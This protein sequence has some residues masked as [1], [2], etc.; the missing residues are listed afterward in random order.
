[1][2]QY[3]SLRE[4]PEWVSLETARGWEP[5]ERTG[6][7]YELR[8]TSAAIREDGTV[9]L[10]AW[11][12]IFRLR[13]A[14]RQEILEPVKILGDHWER[15]YGDLEWRGILPE[16]VL[17]WYVLVTD[18]N[19]VFGWGVKTQP[20]A[21]CSFRFE[22]DR[23]IL[24]LDVRCGGDGV[25]LNGSELPAAALVEFHSTE[26]PFAAAQAFCR[27]LCEAPRM[28]DGPI[29]GGNDWYSA[30]GNNSSSLILENSRMVAEWAGDNEVRPFMVIDD[31]WQIC[32]CPVRG[33]NGGP[34]MMSNRKFP[35]GMEAI[36]SR[37]KELGVRPGIWFRPLQTMEEAPA[38]WYLKTKETGTFLDPS[39]DGVLEWV[40]KDVKRL[41]DWGFELIKHDYS[42]YDIFGRWGFQMGEELTEPGWH[43]SR[44]DLTTAQVLKRF[45]QTLRNAAG[46]KA[47]LI[48]CNTMG[49]LA[50]GFF[51]IQRI[52]DDTSGRKWDVTRK[53]GPNSLA[54][55]MP[56]HGT[57]FAAD[58]DCVG[59]TC[60]VPWKKNKQWLELLSRSGTPLFV[61]SEAAVVGPEQTA[62]LKRA[63][64]YAAAPAKKPG[65]P[66]DW[67]WNRTPAK[68]DLNGEIVSFDW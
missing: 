59:L 13:I 6:G 34:W 48:G 56:Q 65:E 8:D 57:F 19:D 45:Y 53:M 15:G 26:R 29:Y 66:L 14:W 18:G 24:E 40:T 1:M 58:G 54:F 12:P 22:A 55:R 46:E 39:V 47:M 42:T 36:A 61:S 11:E 5:M 62:A 52:G 21:L 50:A 10:T 44:T 38:N 27:Q 37:M 60:N 31:G 23:L 3:A 67:T 33:Y 63:F 25:L 51:E 30:Y 7:L 28:P 64:S 35:E 49:H 2:N 16:R 17:P 68:W 43:F 4:R 41:S 20:N 32:H 9:L